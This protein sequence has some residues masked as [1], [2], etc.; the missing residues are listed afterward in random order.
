MNTALSS[1]RD[2]ASKL[3]NEAESLDAGQVSNIACDILFQLDWID[4]MNRRRQAWDA[5][6]AFKGIFEAG[7]RVDYDSFHD[8]EVMGLPGILMNA[9]LVPWSI[10]GGYAEVDLGSFLGISG[11]LADDL[12][13]LD[14]SRL[15]HALAALIWCSECDAD[16]VQG[17]CPN[18]DCTKCASEVA[19]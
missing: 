1:I 17:V 7:D 2:E 14:R 13:E 8:R 5:F 15:H 3:A 18:P 12:N 4:T 16:L 9:D 6:E 11:N 10:E 19:A